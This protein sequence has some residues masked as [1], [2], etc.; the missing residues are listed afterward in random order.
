MKEGAGFP[1]T[2]FSFY[3][4]D[5]FSKATVSPAVSIVNLRLH[6]KKAAILQGTVQN[7]VTGESI[8]ATFE[9]SRKTNPTFSITTAYSGSFSVLVPSDTDVVFRV[10]ADG[11]FDWIYPGRTEAAETATLRLRAGQRKKLVIRLQPKN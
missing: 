2:Y 8:T 4:N 6:L 5:L 9:L 10:R 1:N 7:A 11:F 3:S